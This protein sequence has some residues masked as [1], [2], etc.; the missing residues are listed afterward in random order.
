M[1]ALRGRHDLQSLA[2]PLGWSEV[3]KT[4]QKTIYKIYNNQVGLWWG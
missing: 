3:S 1:W 2:G 4:P